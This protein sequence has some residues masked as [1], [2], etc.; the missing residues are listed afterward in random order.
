MELIELKMLQALPLEVKIMKTKQRIREWYEYHNGKVYVSSS[1]GKDSTVLLDIV[2]SVYPNVV[3]VFI[4]TGLEYPEIKEFVKTIDNVVTVRPKMAFNKVI[5]KYG[6]PVISKVQSHFIHAVSN[7]TSEVLKN[8]HINGI[9]RDGSKT[10]FVI[11]DKWK[12]LINAPFKISDQCC[13]IMKKNPVKKYEKETGNA[14]I[15]GA[16]AD[17]SKQRSIIYMRNG[18]NSFEVDRP[19]ST[20]LGFWK[21]K[22]IWDYLK[23][24]DLPYSKIYD[25]GETRTGCM[26]CMYGVH[27]EKGENRFQRMQN[28]H[29]KQYD[30]CMKNVEDGG[31]GLA[32]VLDYINVSYKS[33]IDIKNLHQ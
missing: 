15:I 5:Q 11:S 3:A 24:Y 31:L 33:N 28:T 9:N 12:Y 25:M 17:E 1:G 19:I 20:P 16:M 6:Y 29:P 2:R 8:K 13:N 27:M 14:P 30:Y 7:T 32:E 18:C 21:E 10:Q 22:D 4:D 23:L 26:F